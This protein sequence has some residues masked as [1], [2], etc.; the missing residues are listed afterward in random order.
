MFTIFMKQ[1]PNEYDQQ[2]PQSHTIL[3]HE[4]KVTLEHKPR[5]SYQ[6]TY[7][8]PCRGYTI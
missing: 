7:L 1:N 5:Q 8:V 6:L 3:W 2:I 4:E